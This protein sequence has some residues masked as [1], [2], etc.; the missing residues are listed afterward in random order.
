[1]TQ[2]PLTE[3][4]CVMGGGQ[5]GAAN[6]GQLCRQTTPPPPP[7]V[8]LWPHQGSC[9]EKRTASC[10]PVSTFS[11]STLPWLKTPTTLPASTTSSTSSVE[12]VC[13]PL[14]ILRVDTGSCPSKKRINI[15]WHFG[16]ATASC[17]SLTRCR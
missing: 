7:P 2:I 8:V 5:A 17:M 16:L 13:S 11:S 9:C 14:W 4:D 6:A 15:R 10:A 3:P 1:M 12:P